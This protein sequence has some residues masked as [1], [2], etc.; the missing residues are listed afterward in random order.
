MKKKHLLWIP[1]FGIYLVSKTDILDGQTEFV[2]Y[3]SAVWQATCI[4]YAIFIP[5]YFLLN[6]T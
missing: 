1:F 6:Q 4:G 3:A 2:F 5:I